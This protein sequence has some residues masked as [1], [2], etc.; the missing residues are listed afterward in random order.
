MTRL[1]QL[2]R[3]HRK[4]KKRPVPVACPSCRFTC[5]RFGSQQGNRSAGRFRWKV[6][7]R[8]QKSKCYQRRLEN[9]HVHLYE[10][11]THRCKSKGMG[12]K[13]RSV[14]AKSSKNLLDLGVASL[15][16]NQNG[17]GSDPIRCGPMRRESMVSEFRWRSSRRPIVVFCV[18]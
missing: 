12:R 16:E 14:Q 17:I 4:R 9:R 15:P 7:S 10:L 2:V 13:L 5:M 3:Q 18:P 1:R 11:K 6:G 8:P